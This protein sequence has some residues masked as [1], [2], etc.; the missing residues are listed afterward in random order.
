MGRLI[1]SMRASLDGNV[2]MAEGDLGVGAEDEE[3]RTFLD[4]VLRDAGTD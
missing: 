3:V 2:K 1:Y 4:D